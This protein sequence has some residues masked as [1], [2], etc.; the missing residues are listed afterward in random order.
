MFCYMIKRGLATHVRDDFAA[1]DDYV[2]R[3]RVDAQR[4]DFQVG[5]S[6]LPTTAASDLLHERAMCRAAT[7]GRPSP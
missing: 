5:W 7:A 1:F 2:D 6:A 4:Y 3:P